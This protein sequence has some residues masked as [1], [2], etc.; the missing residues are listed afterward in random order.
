[1]GRK[2][3]GSYKVQFP[4]VDGFTKVDQWEPVPVLGNH[5]PVCQAVERYCPGHGRAA[6][7]HGGR[8]RAST[9]FGHFTDGP[10]VTW[11]ADGERVILQE[12]FT[13]VDTAHQRWTTTKGTVSDGASIPRGVWTLVGSPL[14]G[15]Y[16]R[17]ALIHDAY[18]VSRSEPWE[19]V[20]AM[21]YWACRA[22]G[23]E[24][25]HAKIL[26]Y[27]VY[28]FG[29][30]WRIFQQSGSEVTP[31]PRNMALSNPDDARCIERVERFILS[32]D[33]SLEDMREISPYSLGFPRITSNRR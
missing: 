29:P 13:Y 24:K 16:V 2:G 4:L 21:F 19:E 25:A 6:I 5:C 20:H 22:G 28:H 8:G 3:G 14:K 12:D 33:P 9:K 7:P 15:G 27:A 30:R 26:Y 1:M 11:T 18:C 31:G 32:R 10:L 17:A 23:C